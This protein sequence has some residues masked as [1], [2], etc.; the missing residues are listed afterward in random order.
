MISEKNK[1]MLD[2]NRVLA[3]KITFQEKNYS[4]EIIDLSSYH[5]FI[6]VRAEINYNKS[7]LYAQKL[8]EDIKKYLVFRIRYRKDINELMR[9]KYDNEYYEIE[10]IIPLSLENLYLE[11][12]AYQYKNDIAGE[13]L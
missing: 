2:V 12:T 5:D 11:I 8:T 9:I 7:R 4:D 10:S 13:S 6:S 3:H 1:K